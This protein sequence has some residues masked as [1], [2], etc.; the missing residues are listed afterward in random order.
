IL[1]ILIL[2]SPPSV[3]RRNVIRDTWL[4]LCK[5]NSYVQ[6]YF[7]VGSAG[8]KEAHSLIE[9][10][11]SVHHDLVLLPN[12]YD[13]YKSLT[14]K[15]LEAFVWLDKTIKH[16]QYLLKCDDDSF[17]QVD[18]VVSELQT[19][20]LTKGNSL[21][22][23]FFNGRAQVKVNGKWKESDWILCDYYLPYAL[24]GGYVLSQK[25]VH[26]IAVNAEFLRLYNSEDVSVGVWLSAVVNVTRQH[27]PRFNTEFIS[28]G[29]SNTYLVTHK[30]DEVAMRKMFLTLKR[31]GRLCDAEYRSR[32]S[33]IYNWHVP[34]S[35]CCIRNDSSIP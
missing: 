11:Q 16:F 25:L 33:Y 13:N 17:V 10:E 28:R 22:W 34:P 6:Y 19:I 27:D 24:G 4:S 35:K 31:S 8:F 15:V 12:V 14:K 20:K 9:E 23:G 2:S 1:I 18:K 30:Q 7:V 5:N 3:H 29:C 26:F 32:N 21:Y